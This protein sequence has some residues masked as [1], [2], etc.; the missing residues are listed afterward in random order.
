MVR[1]RDRC[2]IFFHWLEVAAVALVLPES[3]VV[4][5]DPAGARDLELVALQHY[6]GILVDG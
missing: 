2:A 5:P 1:A 3:A 4:D 6:R